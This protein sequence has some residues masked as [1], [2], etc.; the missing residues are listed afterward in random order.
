MGLNFKIIKIMANV[1]FLP[2][3][4]F[5][6]FY[7]KVIETILDA[8]RN[9]G[10]KDVTISQLFEEANLEIDVEPL[11]KATVQEAMNYNLYAQ[12]SGRPNPCPSCSVCYIC[13][14]CGGGN[15]ASLAI[16]V[17]NVSK[18]FDYAVSVQK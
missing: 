6:V 2:K 7:K 17:A 16:A 13:A 5:D 18:M 3:E 11:A 12:E 1:N 9:P 14:L 15:A 10:T 8:Q 4:E